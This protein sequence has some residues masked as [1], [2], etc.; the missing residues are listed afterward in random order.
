MGRVG[1]PSPLA[2][3]GKQPRCTLNSQPEA[4]REKD[5]AAACGQ[6]KPLET[7]IIKSVRRSVATSKRLAS[8]AAVFQLQYGYY[9]S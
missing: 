1:Q 2:T 9:V 3:V 6:Q 4:Q 7:Q 8:L 5:M